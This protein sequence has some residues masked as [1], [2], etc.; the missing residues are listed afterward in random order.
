VVEDARDRA[1][2]ERAGALGFDDLAACLQARCNVG[3]SVPAGGVAI[4]ASWPCAHRAEAGLQ[5]GTANQIHD[6]VHGPAGGRHR[7]GATA[8]VG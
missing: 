8:V 6:G 7:R 3:Y 4:A 2:E 5:P 1:L